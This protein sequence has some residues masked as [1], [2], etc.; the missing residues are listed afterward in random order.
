MPDTKLAH[1]SLPIHELIARRWSARAMDPGRRV[2]RDHLV[3]LLEAARWAPSCNGDE[4]WRYIAWDR[5]DNPCGLAAR[6]GMPQSG[7]PVL[8]QARAGDP[9]LV[10]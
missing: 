4:P 7:Q 8:G 5:F 1:T 3:V 6:V 9:G 2:A 10:R